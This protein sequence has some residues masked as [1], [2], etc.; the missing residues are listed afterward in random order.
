M[1]K[2]RR[3]TGHLR[4][5]VLARPVVG[6]AAPH[7]FSWATGKAGNGKRDGSGN[8]N[9]NGKVLRPSIQRHVVCSLLPHSKKVSKQVRKVLVEAEDD[10][11]TL[12]VPLTPAQ[13]SVSEPGSS[14]QVFALW[15]SSQ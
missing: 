2:Q 14:Q 6:G 8:G 15:G 11:F 13:G 12:R 7:W 1:A 4:S 9:G 3:D 5:S 10:D